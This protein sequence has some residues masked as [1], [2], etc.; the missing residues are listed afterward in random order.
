MFLTQVVH[1]TGINWDGVIANVGSITAVLAI[2]GT[3]LSRSIKRSIQDTV[4]VIIR[5]VIARDITPKFEE[6]QF[7]IADLSRLVSVQDR[8]I[9]RLEGIQQGKRLAVDEANLSSRSPGARRAEDVV[10]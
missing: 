4:K 10:S 8:A 1:T 6:I 9:A 5:D 2:V 3:L 7:N